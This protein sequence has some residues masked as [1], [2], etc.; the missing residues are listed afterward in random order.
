MTMRKQMANLSQK[1]A[2]KEKKRKEKERAY[3]MERL[4]ERLA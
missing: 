1:R 4:V 3:G 2:C